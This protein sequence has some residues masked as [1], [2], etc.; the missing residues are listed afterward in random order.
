[1]LVLVGFMVSVVLLSG[2][3]DS[4]QDE[5]SLIGKFEHSVT[6]VAISDYEDM[7]DI[8]LN[9]RGFESYRAYLT[10]L[11]GSLFEKAFGQGFGAMVDLGFDMPLGG[12]ASIS[13][14]YIPV[15]HNGYMYLLVK[16]GLIGVLI[17]LYY[18]FKLI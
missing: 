1:M 10:Y 15:I 17:Y 16:Y 9:W 3:F 12:D 2:A 6:E 18:I 8:N 13:F 14:R 5:M 4:N 11:D 7:S